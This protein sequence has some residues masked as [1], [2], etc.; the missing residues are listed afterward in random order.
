MRSNLKARQEHASLL[1]FR[2]FDRAR[3]D[4][5]EGAGNEEYALLKEQATINR[6]TGQVFDSIVVQHTHPYPSG[7]ILFFFVA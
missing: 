1:N 7:I 2:D 4:P 6:S 3:L 5:E